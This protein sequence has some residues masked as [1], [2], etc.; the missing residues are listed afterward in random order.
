MVS[1]RNIKKI[2]QFDCTDVKNIT[3]N[4]I[5]HNFLGK[6]TYLY[7]NGLKMITES[8]MWLCAVCN[9]AENNCTDICGNTFDYKSG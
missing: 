5:I 6:R 1:S 9:E 4:L 8:A 2:T 7:W 3:G